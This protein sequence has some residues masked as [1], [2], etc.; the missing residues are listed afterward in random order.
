MPQSPSVPR[1]RLLAAARALSLLALLLS[2][3]GVNTTGMQLDTGERIANNVCTACHSLERV[4]ASLGDP[5]DKWS[6]RIGRMNMYGANLTPVQT[7]TVMRFLAS[8]APGSRP[9]CTPTS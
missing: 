7:D 9:V 8:Q 1:L 4:C 5:D 2:C 6:S 3:A